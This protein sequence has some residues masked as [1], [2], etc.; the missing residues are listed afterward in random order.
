MSEGRLITIAEAMRKLAIRGR[1]TF[2][3]H[4]RTRPGFPR[5]LYIAPGQP[6]FRDS[7]FDAYIASL[8]QAPA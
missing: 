4:E 7:D 6:R 3:E 1:S 5:R 2:L 8:E